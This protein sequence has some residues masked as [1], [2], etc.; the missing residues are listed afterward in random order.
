M[1]KYNEA[2]LR[3]KEFLDLKLNIQ[4]VKLIEDPADV[5]ANAENA[6]EAFG[7]LSSARRLR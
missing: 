3:L 4:A 5:P 2:A 7:H 6:R 1:T